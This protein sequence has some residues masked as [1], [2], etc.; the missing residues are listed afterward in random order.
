MAAIGL[1]LG[2]VL[3]L[4]GACTPIANR[5][6]T[7]ADPEAR[8]AI[9]EADRTGWAITTLLFAVGAVVAATGLVLFGRHIQRNHGL[10]T[11]LASVAAAG[12][13]AGA[14]LMA[15][16]NYSR[17]ATRPP[18]EWVLEPIHWTAYAYI[19]LMQI[20]LLTAGVALLRTSYPRWFGGTVLVTTALTVV[21]LILIRNFPPLLFYLI[22]LFMGVA[23]AA[24]PSEAPV[25]R[26]P[27]AIE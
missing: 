14:G 27:P 9:V 19:V 8:I 11:R 10:A 22:T 24:L 18:Q 26:P 7:E 5:F 21:V 13:A 12:A 25:E 4:A 3:F 23:L 1:I 17:G 2:S 6:F 15:A 16:I 20:A